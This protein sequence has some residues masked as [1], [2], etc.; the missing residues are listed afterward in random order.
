MKFYFIRMPSVRLLTAFVL[1]AASLLTT[2]AYALCF[3]T[4]DMNRGAYTINAPRPS[5]FRKTR[6]SEPYSQ[7]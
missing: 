7:P 4:P 2:R 3:W 6:P 1:A 5:L